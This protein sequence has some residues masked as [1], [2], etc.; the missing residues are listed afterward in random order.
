MKY[1][2]YK[3]GRTTKSRKELIT[4]YKR[5][6][7]EPR[8]VFWSRQVRHSCIIE[9]R[10]HDLLSKL[11]NKDPIANIMIDRI[12]LTPARYRKYSEVIYC[13]HPQNIIKIC[14]YFTNSY[15]S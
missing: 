3:V 10:I 13:N 8:L 1:G 6:Y 7:G 2:Y 15:R 12:G 9:K 11:S 14:K 5:A 4:Q